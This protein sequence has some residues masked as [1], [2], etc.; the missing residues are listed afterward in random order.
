MVQLNGQQL[1]QKVTIRIPE[2]GLNKTFQ[3]DAAGRVE[4]SF[5]ADLTLWSPDNPKLYKVEIGSE[6]DRL[7][8]QIGFRSITSKGQRFF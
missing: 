4:F 1:Q 2:A 6:T 3:T 5:D 7:T 8:D